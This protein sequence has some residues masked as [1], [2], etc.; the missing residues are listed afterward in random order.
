M[1]ED[2][3][4]P[5]VTEVR[6]YINTEG[7]VVLARPAHEWEQSGSDDSGL[8]WIVIPRSHARAVIKRMQSLLK[9]KD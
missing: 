9:G 2:V 5:A 1:S 8:I 3:V 4:V 6:C 7:D